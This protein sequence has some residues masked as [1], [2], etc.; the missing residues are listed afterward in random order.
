MISTSLQNSCGP[1]VSPRAQ[2][3][4]R[5]KAILAAVAF[6]GLSLAPFLAAAN[7]VN[8]DFESSTA[9]TLFPNSDYVAGSGPAGWL[10]QSNW[11]TVSGDGTNHPNAGEQS[12]PPSPS[13]GSWARQWAGTNTD[14][15][16][17]LMQGFDATGLAS[18]TE[19]QLRFSYITDD[20]ET[21]Y[22]RVYGMDSGETFSRF[23]PNNCS[24]CDLLIPLADS[25]LALD[26]GQ[27]TTFSATL[28]LPRAFDAI[29]LGVYFGSN[30]TRNPNYIGGIDAVSISASVP[31][32]A[33]IALLGLGL[34]GIG[35]QRR[36]RQ[37]A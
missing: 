7:L 22:F 8:G 25:T 19:L 6:L 20:A 4:C 16:T 13:G 2:A 24:S 17:M 12:A 29:A 33:S 28:T 11:A 34:A 32:P 9:G 15:G 37:T 18:G 30:T 27:W 3:D 23:P 5:A 14:V 21:A 10:D 35:Y 31:E 1:R 36:R 26:V